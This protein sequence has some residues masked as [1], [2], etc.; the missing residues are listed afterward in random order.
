MS[1]EPRKESL[2]DILNRLESKKKRNKLDYS[3]FAP[4]GWQRL[5]DDQRKELQEIIDRFLEINKQKNG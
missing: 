5:T 1:N 3:K 4:I 2:E